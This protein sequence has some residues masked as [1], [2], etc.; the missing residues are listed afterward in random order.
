MVH[1]LTARRSSLMMRGEKKQPISA[2]PYPILLRG[3]LII[4]MA[5]ARFVPGRLA[6]YTFAL[7]PHPMSSST[8]QPMTR[9][10]MRLSGRFAPPPC[11][12]GGAAMRACG[13]RAERRL[14][15]ARC[16]IRRFARTSGATPS[17]KLLCHTNKGLRLPDEASIILASAI[18]FVGHSTNKS[19]I[20]YCPSG[21]PLPGPDRTRNRE[22]N[23]RVARLKRTQHSNRW[24]MATAGQSRTFQEISSNLPDKACVSSFYCRDH[25]HEQPRR[26]EQSPR[27]P[28]QEGAV[29]SLGRVRR[30]RV[31]V[32]EIHWPPA[33]AFHISPRLHEPRLCL[34][35]HNGVMRVGFREDVLRSSI[36][37]RWRA[38]RGTS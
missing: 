22:A 16:L 36:G 31:R 19:G 20:W 34:C 28:H 27:G 25:R 32:T 33:T 11:S 8:R 35:S 24:R 17:T 14:I 3:L 15:H 23:V 1:S 7:A 12:V 37:A 29:S 2:T 10:P 26:G 30:H 21:S 4:L 5:T 38:T 9:L 18:P 13:A 6:R